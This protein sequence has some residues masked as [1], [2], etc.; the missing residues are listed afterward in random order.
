[1]VIKQILI[2]KLIFQM[3]NN[4]ITFLQTIIKKNLEKK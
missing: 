3:M 4:Q 1:M 2:I